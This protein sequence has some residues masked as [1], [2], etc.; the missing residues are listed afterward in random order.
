D[1]VVMQENQHEPREGKPAC[2]TYE[3]QFFGNIK[4]FHGAE[5]H[6]SA[7]DGERS[8]SEWTFDVTFVDGKR[9]TNRQVA[10]RT[11]KDGKVVFERFFYE[12]NIA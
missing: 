1:D 2:R 10:A 11:W 7:V 12:P 6:H 4:E 5:L 3:E 9:M 8:Y